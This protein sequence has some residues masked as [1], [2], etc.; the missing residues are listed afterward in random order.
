MFPYKY[1]YNYIY[2]YFCITVYFQP[3]YY[4]I[5]DIFSTFFNV[6]KIY[7]FIYS[8]FEGQKA[9][10]ILTAHIFSYFFPINNG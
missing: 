4:Y 1:L 3:Y 5:I 7:I 6:I 10:V 9:L 8:I 2:S